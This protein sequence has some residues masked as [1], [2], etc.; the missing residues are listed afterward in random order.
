MNFANFH[1]VIASGQDI[2]LSIVRMGR[3]RERRENNKKRL[4]YTIHIYEHYDNT[5]L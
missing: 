2:E 4:H 3:E 1:L 5:S